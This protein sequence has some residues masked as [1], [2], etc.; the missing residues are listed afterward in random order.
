MSDIKVGDGVIVCSPYWDHGEPGEVVSASPEAI[1]VAV[2]D[3]VMSFDP[4]TLHSSDERWGA[5]L[6]IERSLTRSLFASD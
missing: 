3:G 6:W 4:V 2:G 5:S 1:T